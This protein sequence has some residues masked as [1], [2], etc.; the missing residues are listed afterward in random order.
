MAAERREL[1][2]V[3]DS[4]SGEVGIGGIPMAPPAA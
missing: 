3:F 2:E 1:G 4:G